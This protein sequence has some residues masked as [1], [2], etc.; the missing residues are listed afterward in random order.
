MPLIIML[1]RGEWK[2]SGSR[3]DS[4][5]RSA[6]W[7]KKEGDVS[8]EVP[9]WRN[10]KQRLSDSLRIAEDVPDELKN[11]CS[12]CCCEDVDPGLEEEA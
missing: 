10:K 2:E 9:P 11:L 12:C 3:D 1:G 6:P 7:R 5:L 4:P 8:E